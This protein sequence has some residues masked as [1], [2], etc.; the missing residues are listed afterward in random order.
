M[1]WAVLI[2]GLPSEFLDFQFWIFRPIAPMSSRCAPGR[3][4]LPARIDARQLGRLS[5]T[6]RA[7][8]PLVMV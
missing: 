2:S 7:H 5:R 1:R 6:T 3:A 4:T 8:G